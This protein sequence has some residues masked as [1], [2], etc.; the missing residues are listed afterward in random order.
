MENATN[1]SNNSNDIKSELKMRKENIKLYLE[2][3]E[4]FKND[5]HMLKA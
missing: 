3:I 4:D 2:V 5:L 1:D